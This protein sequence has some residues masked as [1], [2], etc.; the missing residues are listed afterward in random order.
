MGVFFAGA[1]FTGYCE[2]NMK[3]SVI[4]NANIQS[5]FIYNINMCTKIKSTDCALCTIALKNIGRV[6]DEIKGKNQ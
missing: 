6:N 5:I 3:S 2:C 4:D 1:D